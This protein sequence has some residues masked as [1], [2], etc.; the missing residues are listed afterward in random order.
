MNQFEEAQG[1]I[2]DRHDREV[3][4]EKL[5]RCVSDFESL[6]NQIRNQLST[7]PATSK[8]K[9]AI[10]SLNFQNVIAAAKELDKWY[11]FDFLEGISKSD[12]SFL[13][14]HFNRRH[15]FTHNAGRVDKRYIEITKDETVRLNQVLRVKSKEIDRLIKLLRQ[16]GRKL[17]YGYES[18]Q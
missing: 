9:T 13:H 3:E 17:I 1:T 12:R 7:L 14:L 18:I 10:K 4:W 15:L 5:T 11:G 6:A 16:L 8:R 2:R